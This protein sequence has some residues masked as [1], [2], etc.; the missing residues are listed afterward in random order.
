MLLGWFGDTFRKPF[1]EGMLGDLLAGFRTYLE[2]AVPM[3][4]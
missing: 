4:Y 1:S 3:K 2:G